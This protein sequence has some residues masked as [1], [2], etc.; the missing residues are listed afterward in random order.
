VGQG[1]QLQGHDLVGLPLVGLP[2]VGLPPYK[3]F[4]EVKR[5]TVLVDLAEPNEQVNVWVVAVVRELGDGTAR[6]LE[7][8]RE[9]GAGEG[10]DVAA[11][12]ELGVVPASGG[13][14]EQWPADGGGGVSRVVDE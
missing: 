9:R 7:V 2:L 1:S 11:R 12:F 6:H 14:G 8:V 13:A 5:A 10:Q 4:G 3:A